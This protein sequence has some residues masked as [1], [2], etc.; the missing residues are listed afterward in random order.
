[1]YVYMFAKR[2]KTGRLWELKVKPK[3]PSTRVQNQRRRKA[4]P[5]REAAA[6]IAPPSLEEARGSTEV[7]TA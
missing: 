6:W 1:M 3:Q 2:T 5:A 4:H 7:A